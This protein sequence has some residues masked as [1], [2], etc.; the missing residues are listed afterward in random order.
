MKKTFVHALLL[1]ILIFISFCFLGCRNITNTK[2]NEDISETK[3][4]NIE[5][6]IS[7]KKLNIGDS[8]KS[9]KC[10]IVFEKY[11]NETTFLCVANFNNNSLLE[12][13]PFQPKEFEDDLRNSCKLSP[14]GTK[15]TFTFFNGKD[16]DIYVV[17]MDGE[18][19]INLSNDH[20]FNDEYPHFSPDGS[21]VAFIKSINGKR[22]IFIVDPNGTNLINLSNSPES[23]DYY[24]VF[25]LD[26]KKLFFLSNRDENREIYSVNTDGTNLRNLTKEPGDERFFKLSPDGKIIA[27]SSFENEKVKICLMNTDGSNKRVITDKL[28]ECEILIWSPN[29]EELAIVGKIENPSL[30]TYADL[31]DIFL[32]NQNGSNFHN[33]TNTPMHKEFFG[34]W[35]YSGSKFTFRQYESDL[36]VDSTIFIVDVFTEKYK[37]FECPIDHCWEN[38]G[39]FS[40]DGKKILYSICIDRGTWDL[41]VADEEGKFLK[42]ITETKRGEG[43]GITDYK[44]LDGSNLIAYIYHTERIRPIPFDSKL[45]VENIDSSEKL[46]ICSGASKIIDIKF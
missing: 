14:D 6:K 38:G 41:C 10:K 24:P 3:E 30:G 2:R 28:I 18:N 45:F 27:L 43:M 7:L 34:Y 19:L 40:L 26:C 5:P 15:I 33:F 20:T 25:R 21:K 9:L 13:S 11:S 17:G 8:N 44:W 29:G 36:W 37:V 32:V 39:K 4:K 31:N 46:E 1:I 22:E 23:D 42:R 35:S 12:I 16:K